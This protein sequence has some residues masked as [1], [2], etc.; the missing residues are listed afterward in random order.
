ME[1]CKTSMKAAEVR[2]EDAGMVRGNRLGKARAASDG[3]SP[4][5]LVWTFSSTDPSLL[6]LDGPLFVL[7]TCLLM[8]LFSPSQPQLTLE[9]SPT[10]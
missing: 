3:R 7:P 2:D 4:G 10:P 1:V 5:A 9:S 8:D 6:S